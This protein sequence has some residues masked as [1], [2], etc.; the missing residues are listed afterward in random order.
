MVLR[1]CAIVLLASAMLALCSCST[2]R[3]VPGG[4]TSPDAGPNPDAGANCVIDQHGGPSAQTTA[5]I[6]AIYFD[7][8]SGGLNGYNLNQLMNGPDG[9]GREPLSGWEDATPCEVEQQLAWA[10]SYGVSFF[11]FDWDYPP[12]LAP[13]CSYVNNALTTYRTLSN[14]HGVG[15]AIIYDDQGSATVGPADWADAVQRWVELFLDPDYVRVGDKPLFVV[16]DLYFMHHAFNDSPAA[17]KAA[18]DQLRAAAT[19]RGLPGVFVIG[20]FNVLSGAAGQDWRFYDL[21]SY[22][23]EG[24]DAFSMYSY[25]DAPAPSTGLQPFSALVDTAQLIWAE[26]LT[27]TSLPTIPVATIGFDARPENFREGSVVFSPRW[28][29]PTPAEAAGLV[30]AAVNWAEARPEAR[31]EA[32]P[33]PPLV[34]IDAWNEL[35]EGSYL[36]PTV[37]RQHTIGDAI[38]ANLARGSDR[39][40]S[41][42]TLESTT[43]SPLVAS[44]KLVDAA[45]RPIAGEVSVT[46]RALDGDGFEGQYSTTGTVPPNAASAYVV[47]EA[48]W[49]PWGPGVA[50]VTLAG[51]SYFQSGDVTSRVSNGD[52][53]LGAT[54]WGFAGP[55]GYVTADGHTAVAL[56]AGSGV[57]ASM[58]S[59]LFRV[60]PGATYSVN[61]T[62]TVSPTS[63]GNGAWFIAFFDPSDAFI[64][65]REIRFAPAAVP[66]GTVVTGPDGA[67]ALDIS[68]FGSGRLEIAALADAGTAYWPAYVRI[69]R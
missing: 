45:G 42:L 21:T 29:D 7:G 49:G 50:K 19:Q 6:G 52:F 63:T 23:N 25:G 8:W 47:A 26:T 4:L 36:V 1:R 33:T 27:H 68:A 39:P 17:V 11:L 55:A 37:A 65:L 62:G 38:S 28:F 9:T 46:V 57:E 18:F 44:G 51:A 13:C 66:A 12:S 60:T 59:S 31:P 30:R 58:S 61:F 41:V 24:Y 32:A 16:I 56:D 48:N 3:A 14:H 67:F 15:Y 22:E 64:S 43:T 54:G 40:P 20:D 10:S 2:D 35:T 5:R 53:S 34:F 69:E